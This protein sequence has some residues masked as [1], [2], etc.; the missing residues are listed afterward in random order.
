MYMDTRIGAIAALLFTVISLMLVVTVGQA[1][2]QKEL[3]GISPKQHLETAIQ[4][5]YTAYLDGEQIDITTVDPSDYM[6]TVD[7][8]NDRIYLSRPRFLDPKGMIKVKN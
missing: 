7:N 1:V 5:D 8:K 6:I 3:G 2:Q 4:E